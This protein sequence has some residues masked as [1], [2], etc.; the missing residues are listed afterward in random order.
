MILKKDW[1]FRLE[2]FGGILINKKNFDRY[3]LSFDEALFLKAVQLVKPDDAKYIV[4]KILGKETL[5]INRIM[6]LNLLEWHETLP[7]NSIE[8]VYHELLTEYEKVSNQHFLSFPLEITLYPSMVCN[9]NCKFCF[10]GNKRDKRIYDS[11]KWGKIIRESKQ[12]GAL[13]ISIL[14][15]EPALYFD[16]D[17]LLIE[18]EKNEINTIITT[19]ALML[20]ESTKQILFHSKFIT[21]AV[22][23][24]T[25]DNLNM[26]LMGCDSIKQQKF[27]EECVANGKNVR[28]NSVYTFQT[29]EQIARIFDYCVQTGVSRYSVAN[30]A[31]TKINQEMSGAHTLTELDILDKKM[32]AYISSKYGSCSDLPTFSA[33]G[34]MLYS[35]YADKITDKITFSPFEK[36]YFSCRGKYTNMEIYSDGSVYPCFRFETV[37]QS[38]SNI[39]ES[40]LSL[41]DVWHND[42]NYQQIRSQKSQNDI[43]QKCSFIEICEG[44]CYPS[45]LKTADFDISTIRD[46]NCQFC[47]RIS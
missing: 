7:E 10:L 42:L 28:V 29:F 35:C 21:P 11:T 30:Y 13:S 26:L 45:R 22:S 25:L 16:I 12:H 1:L 47:K 3:E 20:K 44:G 24:Q 9:L 19:N 14:G 27:I 46:P 5:N 33:E 23:L 39:F 32:K 17:N 6:E 31:N 43:C 34:C 4:S 15:G 40:N 41:L 18:C 36:Q 8:T 38:T 2:F 37:T